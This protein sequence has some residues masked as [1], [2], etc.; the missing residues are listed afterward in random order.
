MFES[1]DNDSSLQLIILIKIHYQHLYTLFLFNKV[2]KKRQ[3]AL[4]VGM[5]VLSGN[6][7]TLP[8]LL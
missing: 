6:T 1:A 7:N 8:N 2:I 5:E 4:E 3:N